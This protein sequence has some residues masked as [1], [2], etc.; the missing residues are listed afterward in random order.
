MSHISSNIHWLFVKNLTVNV[1]DKL[2]VHQSVVYGVPVGLAISINC[3][4]TNVGRPTDQPFGYSQANTILRCEPALVEEQ[5]LQ[6]QLTV[7]CIYEIFWQR[8]SFY[9]ILGLV[10]LR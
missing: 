2:T 4:K 7:L 10:P 3:S 6:F 1:L 8:S 9:S 5:C